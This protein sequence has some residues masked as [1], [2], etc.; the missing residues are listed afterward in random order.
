MFSKSIILLAVASLALAEPIPQ[1]DV[2]SELMS[3]ASVPAS[4]L[5]GPPTLPS[6]VE[7]V[8][9]TAIPS[10][11]YPTGTGCLTATPAWCSSLPADVKSA[12]SSHDLAFKSWYLEHTTVN[13]DP[14]VLTLLFNI[15]SDAAPETAFASETGASTLPTVTGTAPTEMRT[16]STSTSKSSGAATKFKTG[17][18]TAA[19]G[20]A[21]SSAS[22]GSAGSS[23]SSKATAPHA[24][25]AIEASL[26]GLVGVF[27][28]MLAL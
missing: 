18:S 9:L 14:S 12:I 2:S 7:S 5:S 6:F 15:C 13:G 10:S 11:A 21:G 26:A 25:G 20:T 27:G 3:A 8:L 1:A 17:S 19:T 23:S 22:A 28:L 4:G 16:L 24:T